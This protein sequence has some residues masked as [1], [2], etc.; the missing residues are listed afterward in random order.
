MPNGLILGLAAVVV[1]AQGQLPVGTDPQAWSESDV[2]AWLQTLQLQRSIGHCDFRA[3]H[4][5]P[6]RHGFCRYAASFAAQNIDGEALFELSSDSHYR[7]LGVT[8]V[9]HRLRI[10]RAIREIRGGRGHNHHVMP[11]VTRPRS[12]SPEVSSITS[13]LV[14]RSSQATLLP[15]LGLGTNQDT[16]GTFA[17]VQH[18]LSAGYVRRVL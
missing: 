2:A 12:A 4:V 15:A 18:A 16:E 9:G 17:G 13:P 8:S 7:E 14:L 1:A 3:P 10:R 6:I 11:M 5:L